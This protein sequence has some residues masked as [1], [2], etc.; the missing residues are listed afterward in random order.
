MAL[1]YTRK[2]A[3]RYSF[4]LAI[5]AVIASGLYEFAKS[6]KN[7]SSL[8]GDVIAATGVATLVSFVVG[9]AVIAGLLRYLAKGSFWPFVIWRVGVGVA[10]L[11]LLANG[12]LTN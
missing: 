9:L 12:T 8:G 5:P 2:A 11:V 4:L 3:A 1:G 6:Y 10:V 7:L